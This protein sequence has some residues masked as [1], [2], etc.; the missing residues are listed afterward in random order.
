MIARTVNNPIELVDACI[1][2][3]MFHKM[4]MIQTYNENTGKQ[5]KSK[6][7]AKKK[8]RRKNK[9]TTVSAAKKRGRPGRK[10]GPKPAI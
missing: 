5:K 2:M 1:E 9:K 4:N 8:Q 10:P 3:L 6:E 7:P